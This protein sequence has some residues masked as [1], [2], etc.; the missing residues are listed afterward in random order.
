MA[1][2]LPD[3]DERRRSGASIAQT[4]CTGGS[5]SC[6]AGDGFAAAAAVISK[7]PWAAAAAVPEE[8]C[9]ERCQG[10]ASAE[11]AADWTGEL[12]VAAAL[13]AL[14]ANGVLAR[15]RPASVEVI[16]LQLQDLYVRT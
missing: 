1:A 15:L 12:G 10:A 7:A 5:G 2:S 13:A 8:C 3:P 4:G 11:P 14:S 6:A 16:W 9:R